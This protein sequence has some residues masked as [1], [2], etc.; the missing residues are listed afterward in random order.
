MDP[1]SLRLAAGGALALLLLPL[2]VLAFRAPIWLGLAAALLVFL[3]ALVTAPAPPRPARKALPPP[4]ANG[5]A[6]A[7]GEAEPA[8]ARLQAVAGEIGREPVR[9]QVRRIAAT[10]RAVLE[11]LERE[12]AKLGLVQRL[13][14]YYP[15]R[16]AEI[17]EAY[18][19]L[20]AEGLVK[21]ERV[22]ALE[23]VLGRLAEAAA[24]FAQRLVDAELRA[25]DTEVALLEAALK[26][27]LGGAPPAQGDGR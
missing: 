4:A 19:R 25:L 26:E 1:R 14:T 16:A 17:A 24:G 22:E 27:D 2:A 8:L 21:P 7:W 10:G 11:E 6:A 9:V 15:P 13:L 23:A 12:P 18:V 3:A 5:F 20:E